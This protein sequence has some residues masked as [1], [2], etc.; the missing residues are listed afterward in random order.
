M[1]DDSILIGLS[2]VKE[3]KRVSRRDRKISQREEGIF[4]E[5]S[6]SKRTRLLSARTKYSGDSQKKSFK[7]EI[8]SFGEIK[9][10]SKK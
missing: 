9:I 3:Q 7:E 5:V 6:L 4:Q 8:G 10:L 2:M 1:L